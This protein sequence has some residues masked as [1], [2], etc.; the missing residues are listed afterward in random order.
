M[1][2]V[3]SAFQGLPP[4][5]DGSGHRLQDATRAAAESPHAPG[6]IYNIGGGSRISL[7]EILALLEKISERDIEVQYSDA[8]LGDVKD[9][10]A[11]ILLAER[12]LDYRPRTGI[13]EGLREEFDWMRS[14]RPR[15]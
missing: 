9:T 2:C 12:E 10:G 5:Y 3:F 15:G 7:R 11:D 8:Q 14:G 1:D 4:T 6:G 13:E